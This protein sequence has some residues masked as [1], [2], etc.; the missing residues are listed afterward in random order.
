[1]AINETLLTCNNTAGSLPVPVAQHSLNNSLVTQIRYSIALCLGL[2][3]VLG[4]TGNIFML[5]V[6]IDNLRSSNSSPISTMTNTFMANITVSDMIFLLYNVPVMLLNFIFKDWKMGSAVCISSQSMSM[7]TMFC[8]FY[9]MVATS[10]LRYVAVVHPLWNLS[11]SKTQKLTLVTLMWLLGFLVSIP[12]WLSQEVVGIGDVSYCVL[13]MTKAQMSLYFILFGGIAF[14][15]AM[16][17]MVMCY[18][19]IIRFLW[20][21]RDKMPHSENRLHKNKKVTAT[22]T[23][24]VTVFVVMWIPYWVLTCLSAIHSLPQRPI[25]FVASSLST[26]LAYANC[27]VSPLLYFALSDQ[28]RLKLWRLLRRQQ[29]SIQPRQMYWIEI[30]MQAMTRRQL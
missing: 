12:N 20:C 9:T 29:R 1:M 19:E 30:A 10:I 7:W 26:L 3:F 14:L 23:I 4:I 22:I 6:L 5:L 2:V 16:F 27:C 28:F 15:P 13:C 21:R 11:S 8:S 18:W 25:V 17:L 24:I